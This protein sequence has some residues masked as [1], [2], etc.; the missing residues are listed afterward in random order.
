MA[1]EK[2]VTMAM[3]VV[4]HLAMCKI[5]VGFLHIKFDYIET[6][7]YI[8]AENYS[9]RRIIIIDAVKRLRIVEKTITPETNLVSKP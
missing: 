4:V 5:R 7:L 2:L 6:N 9:P 3:A 1:E 8:H